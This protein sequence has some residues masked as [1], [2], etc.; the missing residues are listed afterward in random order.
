MPLGETY[1]VSPGIITQ[2]FDGDSFHIVDVSV[3]VGANSTVVITITEGDP[4]PDNDPPTP[5]PMTW[6]TPPYATGSSTIA[7]TAT[8]ATDISGVQ[9][10]F[11]CVGGGGNDSGWQGSTLYTDTELSPETTY[12]YTVKARDLSTN[13]NE[14]AASSAEQATTTPD[15]GGDTNWNN[16]GGDRAWD[17]ASNWSAGVPTVLDKAGIRATGI[18]GPIIDTGTSAAANVVVLGD[19]SSVGDTLDITGGSLTVGD[20]FIIA[21][22]AA[23]DATFNVSGGTTTVGSHLDVGRDGAGTMNMTAGT[24]TVTDAFGIATVGGTGEV[25][26]DGGTISSGSIIMTSGGLLDITEGTLI[27]NGDA[28]STING[29]IGNGWITG[30]GGS[31]TVDVDYNVSNPG[32]T[33]VTA[34]AGS[35]CDDGTCDP[36]E[37]QCNC[38]EDCGTPPA[39]ETNCTDGI[40][41]DCDADTD[42]DDPDCVDDPA[43]D[44]GE[45]GDPCT[46][47]DDCCKT[48]NMGPGKCK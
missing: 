14:T 16:S 6:A 27:V 40:N 32:K 30:Y 43:C 18:A 7:M 33:T 10:Y 37:D 26:L 1:N 36:G 24:V 34:T 23:N 22:M 4:I 39:T 12:T 45:K 3:D 13:Q 15:V 28:T 42:C 11:T 38:P 19:W 35:Y 25:Y 46:S 48:C 21:Y 31:G 2:S 44:C 8:T 47:D 41:E 29:Y 17:N 9:Y 5:D 20:W